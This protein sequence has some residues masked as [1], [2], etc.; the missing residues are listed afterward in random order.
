MRCIRYTCTIQCT[1]QILFGN[2]NR[3]A[4]QLS[5][6]FARFSFEQSRYSSLTKKYYLENRDEAALRTPYLIPNTVM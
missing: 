4:P 1:F 6:L 5:I 2:W 3:F